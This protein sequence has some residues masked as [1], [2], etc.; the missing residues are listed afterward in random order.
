[1]VIVAASKVSSEVSNQSPALDVGEGQVVVGSPPK[2]NI[3]IR[4]LQ[5]LV[6]GKPLLVCLP[7]GRILVLVRP[8]GHLTFN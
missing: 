7:D 4:V 6:S 3:N 5:S 8:L 2:D 1:M